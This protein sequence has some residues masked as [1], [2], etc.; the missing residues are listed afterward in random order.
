MRT[1]VLRSMLWG[2]VLCTA[3]SIS[4]F[5]LMPMIKYNHNDRKYLWIREQIFDDSRPSF[6]TVFVGTSHT[7]TAVNTATINARFPGQRSYNFGVNWFGVD[8][9]AVIVQDLLERKRVKN[10]VFEIASYDDAN[11]HEYFR[12]MAPLKNAWG[13]AARQWSGVGREQVLTLDPKFKDA[14]EQSLSV[15]APFVVKGW[16]F[17]LREKLAR[18]Q[19]PE[20]E[21]RNDGWESVDQVWSFEDPAVTIT[22]VH[23]ENRTISLNP[24]LTAII[25]L[26]RRRGVK[27]FF[28]FVPVRNEPLPGPRHVAALAPFGEIIVLDPATYYPAPLW[29][30]PQ[31]LN[32]RGAAVFT[33]QL[34]RHVELFGGPAAAPSQGNQP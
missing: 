3:V 23:D 15:L 14:V 34:L 7:W 19:M 21:G 20:G 1:S 17:G 4:I 33:E 28:P 5:E 30:N 12:F 29:F 11:T 27:L 16:Y 26:C 22:T 24:N 13:H 9:K 6:D 32:T 8:T 31:H 2:L 18:P 25:E 10:L